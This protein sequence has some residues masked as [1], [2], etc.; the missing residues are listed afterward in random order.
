MSEI[1]TGDRIGRNATLKVGCAAVVI[2]RS[3]PAP[4]VLLTR[5]TD[6]GLWC[7]PGGAMDPGESAAEACVREVEEETGLEVEIVRLVGVY[8][9]PH[10]VTRYR[11][12]ATHQ[13]VALCFEATIVGG[14]L[15]LS[16]E[17]TENAWV[18]G[19]RLDDYDIMNNHRE[20]IDDALR[21]D[22]ATVIA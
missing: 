14:E 22:P 5:R 7:L 21:D 11:D 8:T 3:G 10:R 20:R 4:A 16:D 9:S 17:T 19:E 15:G 2:D 18:P 1:L 12:G 13:F 6:N